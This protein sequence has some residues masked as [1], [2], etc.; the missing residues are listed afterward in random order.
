MQKKSTTTKFAGVAPFGHV[1][2]GCCCAREGSVCPLSCVLFESTKPLV[3]QGCVCFTLA[4]RVCGEWLCVER[5]ISRYVLVVVVRKKL[6][7]KKIQGEVPSEHDGVAGV[8]A[9]V[10]KRGPSAPLIECCSRVGSP[11]LFK[12]VL[13]SWLASRATHS[14]GSLYA[15]LARRVGREVTTGTPEGVL[16][17]RCGFAPLCESQTAVRADRWER[18]QR[19][20]R[21][22]LWKR[23][24]YAG[25]V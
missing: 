9:V 23:T 8:V 14:G 25:R 1:V 15:P 7:N 12:G 10:Q 19:P 2:G 4:W 16:R 5:A 13:A 18:N 17:N 20:H 21:R 3:A 11:L 6:I 22:I 24:R